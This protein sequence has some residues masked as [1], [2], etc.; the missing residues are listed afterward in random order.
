[1][2]LFVNPFEREGADGK[3]Y[4]ALL[5][6]VLCS[7]YDLSVRQRDLVFDALSSCYEARGGERI[8]PSEAERVIKAAVSDAKA[9][10]AEIQAVDRLVDRLV[11]GRPSEVLGHDPSP[12]VHEIFESGVVVVELGD[13][14]QQFKNFVQLLLLGKYLFYLEGRGGRADC[15]VLIDRAHGL[16][17]DVSGLPA[18]VRAS[19]RRAYDVL[20][21]L[22]ARGLG[23]H[24]CTPFPSEVDPTALGVVHTFL[25]Y[26][27][28]DCDSIRAARSLLGLNGRQADVLPKLSP[29]E[30][31]LLRSL[32]AYGGAIPILHARLP[33]WIASPPPADE[34]LGISRPLGAV[35]TPRATR[36]TELDRRFGRDAEKAYTILRHLDRSR[37][38][39]CSALTAYLAGLLDEEVARGLT[40]RLMGAGLIGTED[41]G[42]RVEIFLT[43]EGRAALSEWGE[44][45]TARLD[46]FEIE[47]VADDEVLR[48]ARRHRSFKNL[49][50]AQRAL[51]SGDL[52]KAIALAYEAAREAMKE[53]Y[54]RATDGSLVG[55]NYARLIDRLSE[56]QVRPAGADELHELMR[57]R[58]EVRYHGREPSEEE[59][60]RA[61]RIAKTAACRAHWDEVMGGG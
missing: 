42:V 24:L 47:E 26:R 17:P 55:L 45:R 53:V 18:S 37:R 4:A 11:R 48:L 9:S 46:E 12:P 30:G 1:V 19:R 56:L 31:L 15:V 3:R 2:N 58:E 32:P 7:A 8:K 34:D 29:Y 10:Q 50:K 21:R 38:S 23:I 59:A 13:Y 52:R 39:T 22:R 35:E 27:V 16:L 25:V 57:L 41:V 36:G 44:R 43:R 5:A 60:L 28:A 20:D 33:S 61:L 14:D 54:V 40:R 49:V 51:G 6:D